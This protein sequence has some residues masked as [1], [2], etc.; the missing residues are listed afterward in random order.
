MQVRAYD[1]ETD[2][3]LICAWYRGH[4]KT[5]VPRWI[6]PKLGVVIY[7]T[8]G[9]AS[10]DLAALW[11]YMDN[12]CGVCF[13]DKMVA[14]PGLRLGQTRRALEFGLDCVLTMA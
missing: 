7:E 13:V 12:S 6:L 10:R 9:A 5:P 3:P 11:L 4:G 8:D 1:P 2:Y 14:A